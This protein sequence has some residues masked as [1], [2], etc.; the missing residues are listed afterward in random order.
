MSPAG[1]GR[2]TLCRDKQLNALGASHVEA[3]RAQLLS[4]AAAAEA[5]AS[6][7]HAVLL[8]SNNDRSF[9]SGMWVRVCNGKGGHGDV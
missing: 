8:D 5:G 7:V 6:G 4:W 3:L 1:L 2:I 9:C